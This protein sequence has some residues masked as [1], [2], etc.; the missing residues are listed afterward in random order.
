MISR[1]IEMA[2][3]LLGVDELIG[4]RYRAVR[5]RDR[6][7]H[8]RVFGCVVSTVFGTAANYA[9][10]LALC[11]RIAFI[12]SFNLRFESHFFL[13][14]VRRKVEGVGSKSRQ[15]PK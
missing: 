9:I 2:F 13:L 7:T 14:G 1:A 3:I 15:S 6:F 5:K 12:L 8:R 11:E 4:P 10:K